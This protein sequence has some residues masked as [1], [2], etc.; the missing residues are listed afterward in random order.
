M[1]S[2]EVCQGCLDT[3]DL[4]EWFRDSYERKWHDICAQKDFM[5][6]NDPDDLELGCQDCPRTARIMEMRT[7]DVDRGNMSTFHCLEGEGCNEI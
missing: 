6:G 2:S 3:E 1:R 7:K 5:S 4:D